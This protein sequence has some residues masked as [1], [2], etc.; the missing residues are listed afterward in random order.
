MSVEREPADYVGIF[1][2]ESW[3]EFKRFGATVM[4]FNENKRG[5]VS[6]LVR[7]DRILCYL[8]KVSA[9]VGTMEVAGS[10]YEDAS[11]I[12]SDGIYPIRLPVRVVEEVP[13]H[14]AVPI[15]SLGDRLSFMQGRAGTGWTIHVRSSPRRWLA[16]DAAEVRS[17]LEAARRAEALA[18]EGHPPA[19][20]LSVP[21]ASKR[22]S[23]FK[24]SSRVAQ[25]IRKSDLLF[26]SEQH[27]RIGSYESV[28]SFN[29]VTGHS[30]N[31][32]IASTCRPTA[33]CL[34]TCYFAVGAPSWRHSLL[35]QSRVYASLKANPV[36]FA[37][38]VAMEYDRLRLSFLRWNGG[39]D[40]FD[41][42]VDAINHL[43][44]MRPDVILWVVTRIP[45]MAAKVGDFPNLFVHFSLDRDSK[46][47]AAQ[48]LRARPRSSRYFFSYQCARG[49]VPD[50][51]SLSGSSV[52]FFDNYQ[53]T[54]DLAGL[55]PEVVCPLNSSSS[56][57]GVCESC[58]R[59]FNGNA[60][61]HRLQQENG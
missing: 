28:L 36:E 56:I 24:G 20:E 9:F 26:S 2:V 30:I 58:R 17:A 35:H 48:F 32:P 53:P 33:V 29:K 47:R 52:L 23:R 55:P 6:R 12:W 4:G 13:L 38:R 19:I 25:I 42:S 37:E 51:T 10:S 50:L 61:E 16:A 57:S 27:A 39:G 14:R 21:S 54:T 40:L 22:K 60:V 18:S 59:C 34:E 49:E 46:G 43:A 11:T 31:V 7:G 3:R 41:E 45:E 15:R 5:L 8:S 44:A 1:T